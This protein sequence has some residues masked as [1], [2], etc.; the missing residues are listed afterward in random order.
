MSKIELIGSNDTKQH[1]QANDI[2]EL[3]TVDRTALHV[4]DEFMGRPETRIYA[5]EKNVVKIRA[6][7]DLKIGRAHV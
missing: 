5:N 2:A 7:L 1:Y 6:E 4:G 3:L